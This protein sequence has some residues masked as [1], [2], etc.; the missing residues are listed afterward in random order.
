M[1]TLSYMHVG[2]HACNMH[3]GICNNGLFIWPF[4]CRSFKMSELPKW[5]EDF[6]LDSQTND[7]VCMSCGLR[8]RRPAG[9]VY[10]DPEMVHHALEIACRRTPTTDRPH[11]P[12]SS[13]MPYTFPLV[14]VRRQL[15]RINFRSF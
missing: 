7:F 13:G 1:Y 3:V 10:D 14:F 11:L 4:S 2:I 15:E 9:E 6:C 5:R 8:I 12:P